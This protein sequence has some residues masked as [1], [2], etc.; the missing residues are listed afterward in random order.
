MHNILALEED[1][2]KDA[3]A[4]PVVRLDASEARRAAR[5]HRRVVDVLAGDAELYAVEGEA[6]VWGRG[7]A[8]E[9]VSA[10]GRAVGSAGDLCVVGFDDGG[11]QVQEGG[12]RVGD[13]VD[14]RLGLA[15]G[16]DRVPGE[17]ELPPPLAGVDVGVGD[18][19]R[20]L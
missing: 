8:R 20:V 1:V 16:A 19:A 4:D 3:E 11:G 2:S 13:A 9:D 17:A 6:K 7:R 12:A 14:G 15:A 5:L 10:V 18:A